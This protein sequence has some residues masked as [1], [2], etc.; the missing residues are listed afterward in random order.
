M[1]KICFLFILL[2]GSFT[3]YAQQTKYNQ[4]LADS[5][6]NWAILDQTAAGPRTGK[7]KE[8][9]TTQHTV[10]VDSVFTLNERRLSAIM[11]K[12]GFPGYD[13]VGKK[14]SNNF[15]LMVQHFDK[16]VSF[17]LRVLKAMKAELQKHNADSQNFAYLTDRV[18]INTGH[19]QLYGTQI[20]YNTDSCQAIP[21]PMTDSLNVNK[22]RV[23]IGIESIESYL[24]F[25][26]QVYFDRNKALYEGKA[27]YKPKLLP[28]PNL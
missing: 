1:K 22:R 13:L 4:S 11:D 9:T 2:V 19:K 14:G 27:V 7:F 10:Y 25:A 17:Q 18:L 28:E 3:V 8:M 21:K 6:A 12:Y 24:N 16:N 15:W 26:S 23:T 5:L 20:S